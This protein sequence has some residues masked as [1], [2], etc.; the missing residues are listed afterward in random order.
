MARPST[1]SLFSLQTGYQTKMFYRTP[2]AAFFTIIFP[3][4]LL[5]LFGALFGNEEIEELGVTLAQYF[6]PAL[7]VFSA[8]NATYSNIGVGTAFQRDEGILKRAKGTPLP[9]WIFMGGKVAAS[10]MIAAVSVILM[11]GVGV[12]AYGIQIYPRT[13]PAAIVTFLVGTACFAC[14]GLLVAAVAPSGNAA[15]EITNATLLPLAF[16]SGL[17]IP[18]TEESPQWIKTIADIFPL[19]YFNEAFQAA[20]LP[21]TTGAQFDWVA[22]GVMALWGGVA[23][24]LG[25]RLFKWETPVKAGRTK[26]A[27]QPA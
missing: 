23:L 27:N 25:I 11:M 26:K 9:A 2:I 13:L 8:A 3:L 17:F 18:I 22:L 4:M 19:S 15:T 21:G 16:L 20:F 14:L 5:I 1:A 12:L 7:A 24:I 10:T 6:A